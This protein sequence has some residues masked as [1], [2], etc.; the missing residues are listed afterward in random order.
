MRLVDDEQAEPA[1]HLLR[2]LPQRVHEPLRRHHLDLRQLTGAV[3]RH[4]RVDQGQVLRAEAVRKVRAEAPAEVPETGL[5]RLAHLTAKT[6]QRRHVADVAVVLC[7]VRADD[8]L[9][10]QRLPSTRRDRHE[11][12]RR[13]LAQRT[14]RRVGNEAALRR[15]ERQDRLPVQ[16][17]RLLHGRGDVR[18]KNRPHAALAEPVRHSKQM[19][20][21]PAGV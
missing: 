9:R 16:R 1:Q 20:G 15:P 5:K 18:R 21:D 6:A 8:Q 7:C 2:R 4:L 14:D 17:E 10:E 19:T 11:Q 13:R 12:P 3:V